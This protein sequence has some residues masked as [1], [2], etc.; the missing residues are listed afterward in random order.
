MYSFSRALVCFG[1]LVWSSNFTLIVSADQASFVDG[2]AN[3]MLLTHESASAHGGEVSG[4]VEAL[5]SQLAESH[6]T[7][8]EYE[9]EIREYEEALK[10]KNAEVEV[11]AKKVLKYRDTNRNMKNDLDALKNGPDTDVATVAANLLNLNFLRL[12]IDQLEVELGTANRELE[13]AKNFIGTDD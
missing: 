8:S 1:C 9:K 5:L 6:E 7:I 11:L 12:K 13:R 3:D 4:K 10:A 2:D